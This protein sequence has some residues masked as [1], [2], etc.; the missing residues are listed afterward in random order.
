M[1]RIFSYALVPP[2]LSRTSRSQMSATKR[3]SAIFFFWL[4]QRL[5]ALHLDR[6]HSATVPRPGRS[7]ERVHSLEI[8]RVDL[9]QLAPCVGGVELL[10]QDLTVGLPE[11]AN[12]P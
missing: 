1:A 10:T 8:A 4:G 2:S 9:E 6:D 3:S 7:L 5:G 12:V 11:L